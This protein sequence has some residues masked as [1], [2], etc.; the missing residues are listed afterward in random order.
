[1]P[2]VKC[3]VSNC[4]YWAHQNVCTAEQI[5][6]SAGP[7]SAKDKHGRDAERL[8]RTPVQVAEDSYCWTFEARQET[9]D[10]EVEW[11]EVEAAPLV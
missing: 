4:E 6:I 10:E 11:D 2:E 3:T 9:M 7:T 8:S 5:L 1:M